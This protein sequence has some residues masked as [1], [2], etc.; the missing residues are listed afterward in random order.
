[1]KRESLLAMVI[2]LF[3]GYLSWMNFFAPEKKELVKM[4][5]YN[6]EIRPLMSDKCFTC[7]GPDVTKVKAGLRLDLPSRAFA[8]LE[9][10]KGK[11]AI[12]PG[13][14]EQSELIHRIES[15]DPEIMMPLPES[16]LTRLRPDEI[17]LFKR[18]IKEGAQYEKHWAFEVPKKANLPEVNY[19]SWTTNE[20]DYFIL[21]KMEASEFSPNDAASK[22][23]L[24]KRAYADLI[25]LPPSYEELTH[26]RSV[27]TEDWY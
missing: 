21:E 27:S 8:E 5:S 24:I 7:H 11:Y 6:R 14:P 17:A 1:M 23:A 26:W 9:K 18:W 13:F 2:L 19:P 16:H 15:L 20:V 10:T 22:D 3:I 12:V 4:V 25:G